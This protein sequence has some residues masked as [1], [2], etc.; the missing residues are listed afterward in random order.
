M[1]LSECVL[2]NI[3]THCLHVEEKQNKAITDMYMYI[4]KC[5]GT[6]MS[7]THAYKMIINS[8]I[9][10][11]NCLEKI[12]KTRDIA[13]HTMAT[14]GANMLSNLR[15]FKLLQD[16]VEVRVV[17]T[18][19]GG[20]EGMKRWGDDPTMSFMCV[21]VTTPSLSYTLHYDF[22]AHIYACA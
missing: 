22:S 10:K 6:Y 16:C 12:N 3:C 4:P 20:G 21:C 19:H 14:A 18:Y 2:T 15:F 13:R 11:E 9:N 17:E 7:H 8:S 5:G 1:A